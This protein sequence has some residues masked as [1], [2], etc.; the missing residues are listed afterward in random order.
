MLE[1]LKEIVHQ[2]VAKDAL[3]KLQ[4]FLVPDR[5]V[6]LLLLLPLLRRII[7]GPEAGYLLAFLDHV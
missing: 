2:S 3:H 6:Y 4:V 5:L 1:T 7:A